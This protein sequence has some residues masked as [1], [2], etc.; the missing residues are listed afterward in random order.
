M[1]P[2]DFPEENFHPKRVEEIFFNNTTT[3]ARIFMRILLGDFWEFDV[4]QPGYQKTKKRHQKSQTC[5]ERMRV[6]NPSSHENSQIVELAHHA[7]VKPG[8]L[9]SKYSWLKQ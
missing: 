3:M 8:S 2:I 4:E 5:S 6:R 1:R 7:E 9:P